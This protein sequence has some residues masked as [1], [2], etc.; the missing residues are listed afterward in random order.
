[1]RLEGVPEQKASLFVRFTYWFTR[2]KFG[3]MLHTVAVTAHHPRLLQGVGLYEL[4]LERCTKVPVALK[5]LASV[6]V[7]LLIGCPF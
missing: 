2:R 5:E 6:R 7:A 3:K 4:H 1:M